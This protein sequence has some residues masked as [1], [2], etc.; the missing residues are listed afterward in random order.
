MVKKIKVSDFIFIDNKKI[1][2][3]KRSNLED[4]PNTWS[5]P[6]GTVDE[7][8]SFEA[9][10]VREIKEELN[11]DI[12]EFKFWKEYSYDLKENVLVRAKYFVGSCT[13]DIFLDIDEVSEV[14]WFDIDE[15]LLGLN[16]AFN[17]KEV[18]K[19]FLTYFNK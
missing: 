12:K 7:G 2:L 6:G 5:I 1:L 17:Q 18:I 15:S 11:L 13:G 9:A 16:F 8:E 19:D 10:L 3:A 14:C 4:F